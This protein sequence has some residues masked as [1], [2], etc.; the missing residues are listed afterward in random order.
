MARVDWSIRDSTDSVDSTLLVFGRYLEGRGLRESTIGGYKECLRRYLNFCGTDR[1]PVSKVDEFR[2]DMLDRHLSRSSLNNAGFAIKKF[3]EMQGTEIAIPFLKANSHIPDFFREDEVRR[4]FGACHNLK[5]LA[6]LNVL[7]YACL[8]ASELCELDLP[9]VDLGRMTIRV[10]QGKGGK[11][12]T[13]FIQEDCARILRMYLERRPDIAVDGRKP[14][15]FTDSGQRFDRKMVYAMF[16]KVKR[17]A[18]IE[19][20][21]GLHVFARHTPASLMIA[22]GAD[23]RVIQQILRHKSITT[24]VKYTHISNETTRNWYERTLKLGP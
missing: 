7:F 23:I 21:G 13:T 8:R 16:S 12:G 3:Y 15:F 14:L 6:M 24:T 4:I 1:P 5:H 22:K 17:R 18:Q 9:D 11:D 19:R 2:D 10:R 20:S